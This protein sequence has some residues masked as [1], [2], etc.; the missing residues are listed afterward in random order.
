M[1][2]YSTPFVIKPPKNISN[3]FS[4]L[5]DKEEKTLKAFGSKLWSTIAIDRDKELIEHKKRSGREI[6]PIVIESNE[7]DVLKLPW[8]LL[9]HPKFGFLAKNPKFT[10]SRSL[11]ETTSLDNI[12]QKTPLRILHFSTLPEELEGSSRLAVEKEQEAVLE[13]LLPFIKEGWV[14]L[15]ISNDGRFESLG[16]HIEKYKSHLVF[17]SGH[18]KYE[19]GKGY[20]LFEDKRGSEKFIDEENFTLAFNG[21]TV[22]CV[23]LSSCQSAKAD[24][25]KLN[26]GL[27]RALA[28]EGIKNVIGM[29]DSIYDEAGILFAKEF[30]G[31]L[32]KNAIAIALQKARKK[33]CTLDGNVSSHWFLPIL[34][35]QNIYNFLV[36]WEFK[37]KIPSREI[38]SQKLNQIVFPELF[39]GRRFEFRKFYN[40]LYDKKLKKLLIYGEGGTGKSALAGKFGL[41]LRHEGYKVFDVSF[42]LVKKSEE[43]DDEYALRLDKKFDNFLMDIKFSL[44]ADGIKKYKEIVETCEEDE[45]CI[46]KY[47]IKL[48]LEEN[49][50]IAFIFDNLE[51]IQNPNSREIENDSIKRWIEVINE[52]EDVVLL[53][54]SRWLVPECEES[55][56]LGK[57]SWGDFLY[58]ISLQ[59]IDFTD[60]RRVKKIYETLGGNYR[61][62]EYFISAI[63]RMK[64]DREEDE[65]LKKLST[66]KRDIQ[67]NMA[68]EE[69]L[70]Y[71]S[72][73]EVELLYRLTVYDTAVPIEGIIK[74][75]QDLPTKECLDILV[76]FSLVLKTYNYEYEVYE[77][78]I[79]LLVLDFIQKDIEFSDEI[80]ILASEYQVYL[81]K[82]ERNILS[83][84]M[85]AHKALKFAN[86]IDEADKLA[87]DDIVGVLNLRGYYRT[88]L[89]E[90]LPDIVKS[91][92]K[93]IRSKALNVMGVQYYS[94]SEFP[95][96]L[97]CYNEALQ[98][99]KEID[100]KLGKR[101]AFNNL[102]L[103]Y[104]ERGE[105]VE[106]LEFLQKSLELAKEINDKL[107]EGR[108]RN[109]MALIYIY[110]KEELDKALENFKQARKIFR[111]L[112]NKSGEGGVYNNMAL[113]YKKRGK[114][115]KALIYYQKSCKLAREIDDKLGERIAL[116]NIGQIYKERKEPSKALEY[117]K[118]SINIARKIG[119]KLGAEKVLA[120]IASIHKEIGTFEIFKKDEKVVDNNIDSLLDLSI[121]HGGMFIPDF[122]QNSNSLSINTNSDDEI[123][124]F[125][126][127]I[128]IDTKEEDEG[129]YFSNII[130]VDREI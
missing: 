35:S 93:L 8:E 32:K 106:S 87:L 6:L 126:D 71:R 79:S 65:F 123:R 129:R 27:T 19:D 77:Y 15:K 89:D 36:D 24:S 34:I 28:F 20:F 21:S 58:Y 78:G 118:N 57:P 125:H 113:I 70:S 76:S 44:S 50:K 130:E 88:L 92:D 49:R 111:E 61:G 95:K 48:L 72:T 5:K 40:Y 33:I 119:D 105:I 45:A 30:M 64:S 127:L 17:L 47:L 37:P 66:A 38:T 108:V 86:K 73:D 3:Q 107:G 101:V 128:E 124:Y 7:S 83:Q 2:L 9:Y 29:S 46:A 115:D 85:T 110:Q 116:N 80:K 59:N 90:W 18:S 4:K 82:N 1:K 94:L 31:N 22:E 103:L 25:S 39:I 26:S 104:K 96:A 84:A 112:D 97:D 98:I 81:F 10:L 43:G 54:T 102:A 42:S 53:L 67:V 52:S 99:A 60:E 13:S 122:Q 100:Y 14:E 56:Q 109:N 55:I 51:S 68:I 75:S 63:K 74:I 120:K 41:E 12:P 62:A 121:K 16:R 23:V 11:T 69:I 91:K 114:L 117:Y